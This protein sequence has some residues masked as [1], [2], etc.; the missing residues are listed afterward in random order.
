MKQVTRLLSEFKSFEASQGTLVGIELRHTLKKGQMG[1]KR[2]TEGFTLG[3]QFY[4]L[5][6]S[7]VA[8]WGCLDHPSKFAA[9][10]AYVRAKSVIDTRRCV[11]FLRIAR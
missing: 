3:E 1:E 7:S 4:S 11:S 5:A 2:G 6:A 8:Q 10:L 9:D